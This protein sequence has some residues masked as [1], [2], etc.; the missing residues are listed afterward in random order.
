MEYL[1]SKGRRSYRRSWWRLWRASSCIRCK[2]PRV[3]RHRWT[4]NNFFLVHIK[5][6]T[7]STRGGDLPRG[8]W[9][10]GSLQAAQRRSCLFGGAWKQTFLFFWERRFFRPFHDRWLG[11]CSGKSSGKFR[12][13]LHH[14]CFSGSST[15]HLSKYT[16]K[17]WFFHP[18]STNSTSSSCSTDFV[19][20]GTPVYL[21]V[22]CWSSAALANISGQVLVERLRKQTAW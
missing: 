1:S 20:N 13:F 5:K 10:G 12:L 21:P 3:K 17:L 7:T 4:G 18:I 22:L 9:Q 2:S 6:M 11:S 14:F 8:G 19:L 15:E 16:E